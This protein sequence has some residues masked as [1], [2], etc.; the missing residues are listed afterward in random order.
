M[1]IH[2]TA[3]HGEIGRERGCLSLLNDLGYLSRRLQP[4]YN[5][6]G[7]SEARKSYITQREERLRERKENVLYQ[8]L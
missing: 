7:Q 3:N 4:G 6:V 1:C 5:Y 8:N 2:S